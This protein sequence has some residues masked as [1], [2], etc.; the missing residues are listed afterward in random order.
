MDLTICLIT[1]GRKEYLEALLSSLE[2][3][4][5]YDW[6]KVLVIL[7]GADQNVCSRIIEWAE[8]RKQV[9]VKFKEENDV[10][11]SIL[12]PLIREHTDGWCIFLSDDDLFNFEI[13]PF[14]QE[15]VSCN[16]N[17]VAVSTFAKV[18]NSKGLE[19]G[20]TKR[21]TLSGDLSNIES[22]ALSLN[23]PPFS[24]PTLF[25]D[26]SKLP[27][28][29]PNS[30][31]AFDWWVGIQLIIKGKIM[32]LNEY[33]IYYRSHPLQESNLS[34]HKR[35]N[36][37]TF[38]WFE[39]ILDSDNFKVWLGG[40]SNQEVK[41]FWKL[42]LEFPPIYGDSIYSALV[43]NKLRVLISKMVSTADEAKIL[44][45]FALANGVLLKDMEVGTLL[46][47][48]MNHLETLSNIRIH[49]VEGSCGNA[50]EI[51]SKFS[52]IDSEV[53]LVAC[54]HYRNNLAE[55]TQVDCKILTG[56]PTAVIADLILIA[57]TE[58]LERIGKLSFT[59]TPKEKILMLR[60][61]KTRSYLPNP[62]LN[63][64]R[65]RLS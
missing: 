64:V 5:Q 40:L 51:E 8:A 1:K 32:H 52:S 21:S 9:I 44:G 53:Y 29:I 13:L 50:K 12:W 42:C 59:L 63:L 65:K 4:F 18:I 36:F 37:D 20:E 22:I 27:A 24:W 38:V 10:R 34:S 61:R 2:A 48:S 56:K 26:I 57:V 14:W 23:Q 62:I 31:Y 55:V 49:F 39:S 7:N 35:K 17:L 25:F 60:I 58:R 45:D 6:V 30:R 15:T 33:S 3:T 41:I 54:N 47:K 28:E 46:P 16:K 19:T 11:P 43:L